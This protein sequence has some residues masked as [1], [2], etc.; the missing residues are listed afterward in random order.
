MNHGWS[1]GECEYKKEFLR[2]NGYML[3]N[4]FGDGPHSVKVIHG[5]KIMAENW[6]Q[7]PK[8]PNSFLTGWS[9]KESSRR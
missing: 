2:E 8:H 7:L 4:P 1:S 6:I 5:I 3:I 9:R